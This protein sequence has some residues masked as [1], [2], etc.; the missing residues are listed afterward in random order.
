MS[1]PADMKYYDR[2][3]RAHAMY[4]PSCDSAINTSNIIT[5]DNNTIDINTS[6]INTSGIN[7]SGVTTSGINTSDINTSDINT[8]GINTSDI[9]MSGRLFLTLVVI[10]LGR[11]GK[12]LVISHHYDVV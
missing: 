12:G 11:L 10:S 2:P 8:S 1:T 9:N 4:S 3:V 5:I 7:T 6:G